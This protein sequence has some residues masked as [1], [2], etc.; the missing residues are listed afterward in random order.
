MASNAN[1][2]DHEDEVARLRGEVA[3]LEEEILALKARDLSSRE[4][5][6]ASTALEQ[7][8]YYSPLHDVFESIPSME[9]EEESVFTTLIRDGAPSFY[10]RSGPAE[11]TETKTR[12]EGEEYEAA[13]MESTRSSEESTSF[14]R[15]LHIFPTDIFHANA[16]EVGEL[17]YLIPHDR[18]PA[19]ASTYADVAIWSLGLDKNTSW[20]KVQKAI[21]GA[22]PITIAT[23][24]TS[25]ARRGSR[26]P[27]TGI[28]HFIA[29]KICLYNPSAYFDRAHY[30]SHDSRGDAN[31]EWRRVQGYC[32]DF[33]SC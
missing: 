32:N 18:S 15:M 16:A 29:N 8:T 7:G 20:E 33:K 10:T 9:Y 24:T 14:G 6:S 31:V 22:K 17:G 3:S 12:V 23:T 25:G 21:H 11:Y 1:H 28:K 13:I 27:H 26:D 19:A 4:E 5:L 30:S 2:A